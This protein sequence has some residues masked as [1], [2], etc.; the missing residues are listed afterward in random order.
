MVFDLDALHVLA[1]DVQDTVH[2]GIEESGCLVVGDCLH[3]SVVE[4]Q[5]CFDQGF[6]VSGGTGTDY[7]SRVGEK[8]IDLTDRSDTCAERRTVI[9][10]VKR[11]QQRTVFGDKR[12]LGRGGTRIYAQIDISRI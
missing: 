6:S 8:R 4:H 1:A 10:G 5:S 7:V 9:I 3:F 2:I 11:I 12:C